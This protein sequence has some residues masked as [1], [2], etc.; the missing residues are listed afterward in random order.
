LGGWAASLAIG[1]PAAAQSRIYAEVDTTLATVGDRVTLTVTVDHPAGSEV[2]WPDSLVLGPFEVL[3][4]QAAGPLA[5]D[6]GLRSTAALDLAAFELGD[7]EIPSFDVVVVGPGAEADTLSTDA[8]GVQVTSVGADESGDIRDIRG[9]FSIPLSVIRVSLWGLAALAALVVG[10][11]LW[12]RLRRGAEVGVPEP[13]APPRPPHEVA[14]EAL[15]RLEASP[16]LERGLVKEYHIE[17][18]DILRRYVEASFGV[19]ALEMTTAEVLHGLERGL[20]DASFRDGLGRFLFA[21]DM[22]KF[23]KVRPSSQASRE[24]LALGRS[25]VVATVPQT[26]PAEAAVGPAPATV[27]VG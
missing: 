3:D 22:V 16:L 14:L 15:A 7:L 5:Q 6:D 10:W 26:A 11:L 23:A 21:C 4:A 25:L 19:A 20:A 8:F 2:A 18:S 17:V 24:V 1:A 13:A 12:R 9:P 27:E